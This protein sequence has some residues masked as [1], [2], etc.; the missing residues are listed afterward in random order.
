MFTLQVE[1]R[2]SDVQSSWSGLRPL[3]MDPNA[4]DT[5]SASRDHIVTQDPDGLITV[6]G[7]LEI[8][9]LP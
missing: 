1:V 6:T 3:A 4:A 2:R 5:A 8:L 9:Q 7:E